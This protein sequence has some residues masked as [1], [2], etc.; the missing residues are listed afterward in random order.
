MNLEIKKFD[1]LTGR[2][3]YEILR[4]RSEIFVVEQDCV[5]NDVDEK[6]LESIHL[7]IREDNKIQAYLRV[8]KSGVSYDDPSIGRVLVT[9]EARGKG[10]AR[11]IVQAGINYITD[12][13]GEKKIT[14]GAQDYLRKFYES[15]GFEAISKVYLED[16]IPHLDMTYRKK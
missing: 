2:E 1:E 7:M 12:H 3:V 14:I 9:S 13:W 11:K 6:D 8:L 16:R 10:F 5:Y 4:I 15:L